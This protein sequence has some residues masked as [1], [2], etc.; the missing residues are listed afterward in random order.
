LG[1][2]ILSRWDHI[3][4]L[5]DTGSSPVSATNKCPIERLGFFILTYEYSFG[6]S[7]FE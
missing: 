3:R 4:Q 7:C 1:F 6:Y 2:F 5:T